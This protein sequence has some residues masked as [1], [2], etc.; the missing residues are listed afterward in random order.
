MSHRSCVFASVVGCFLSVTSTGVANADEPYRL[1]SGKYS[2]VVFFSVPWSSKSD[3]SEL[4]KEI[5]RIVVKGKRIEIRDLK[6]KN[7]PLIGTRTGNR[8]TLDLS[9]AVANCTIVGH[10]EAY[11]HLRYGDTRA[12]ERAIWNIKLVRIE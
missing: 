5:V 11:G 12:A 10:N 1:E 4:G 8:F 6:G 2:V 3:G 7:A 9:P